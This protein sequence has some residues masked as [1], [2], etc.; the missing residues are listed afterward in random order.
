MTCAGGEPSGMCACV[1][2]WVKLAP[3]GGSRAETGHSL[4]SWAP[5]RLRHNITL[6]PEIPG[7]T[8]GYQGHPVC[9]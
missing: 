8:R 4:G 5:A 7:D 6:A 9:V 1:D 2:F 3:G